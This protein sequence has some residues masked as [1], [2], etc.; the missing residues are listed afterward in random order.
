MNVLVAVKDRDAAD[1][2]EAVARRLGH[3]TCVAEGT[4]EAY[5]KFEECE[6]RLV[7]TEVDL[8]EVDGFEL[9]RKIRTK[10]TRPF[11]YIMIL[12]DKEIRPLSLEMAE[13]GADAFISKPVDPEE[14]S[15][16]MNAGER[17]V[18]LE[19]ELKDALSEVREKN[20]DL[21]DALAELRATQA[22]MIQ[23]EKMSS[24]GQL[25]A[26][27]AHE[28]NNPTGFVKT[29]LKTL[30]E[31]FDDIFEVIKEYRGLITELSG[32]EKNEMGAGPISGKI[33]QIVSK[34]K[35]VDLDFLLEDIKDIFEDC[36]EGTDR[37]KKIVINLKEFAHPGDDELQRK[38]INQGIESTLSVI[39][40]ELKYKAQ[41]IKELGDLPLVECY[42]QQLN[43]VFMNILINAVQ[44]I[45]DHGEIRIRTR[46]VENFVEIEIKDTGIGIPEV[47]L[48]KIYDPFFTTKEVGKGTG[49]GLNVSYNIVKRHNG[50]IEVESE[51]G[52]GTAFRIKIPVK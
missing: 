26:G 40:N 19:K 22:Q 37:I 7:A 45:K 34:E 14:I 16:L 10:G 46:A 25:A 43:Q 3:E 2:I 49:L 47:N 13:F 51:M 42:P 35:E 48:K 17:I 36:K 9:C 31:Y 24:I 1:I 39:W 32:N 44:A 11:A 41:V 8:P 33:D 6:I 4:D 38:D 21:E 30:R 20:R 23:S 15:A 27:I 52:R 5:E 50:S 18:R 29:N 12:K 28:I